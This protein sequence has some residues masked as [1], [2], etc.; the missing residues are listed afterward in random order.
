MAP[1]L[2]RGEGDCIQRAPPVALAARRRLAVS[3]LCVPIQRASFTK[4]DW[5]PQ[6]LRHCPLEPTK[7]PR[8]YSRCYCPLEG[9]YPSNS[10]LGASFQK[11]FEYGC[12]CLP[13]LRR[14][15]SD[16]H[17]VLGPLVNGQMH[18][19]HPSPPHIS[20]NG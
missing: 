6:G 13:P 16:F 14:V 17:H 8:A 5:S 3:P 12:R 1:A 7:G 10:S 2:L 9:G 19:W 15:S 18:K 4:N 20:T 11:G